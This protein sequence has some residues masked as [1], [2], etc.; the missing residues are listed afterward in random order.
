MSDG[1]P[2]TWHAGGHFSIDAGRK[3][4]PEISA[5]P[6]WRRTPSGVYVGS[7]YVT[8]VMFMDI[9]LPGLNLHWTPEAAA[10]RDRMLQSARLAKHALEHD[11]DAL[12]HL[13]HTARAPRKHQAQATQAMFHHGHRTLLADDMGLGKTSTALWAAFDSRVRR[14]FIV[15]PVGVKFNWAREIHQTLG[16]DWAVSIIAGTAKQRA[17]LLA[18]VP[19]LAKQNRHSA[20]IINYDLLRYLNEQQHTAIEA[21]AAEQATLCDESQYLKNEKAQRSQLVKQL[22]ARSRTMILMSGT[23]IMD[24]SNDLYAQIELLRPGTWRSRTDFESRYIVKRTIE[25]PGRAPGSVRKQEIIVGTKNKTELNT[26]VNTLQIRRMKSEVT[27]MPPKVFTKPDLE[28]DSHTRRLYNAM[29]DFAR[30]EME[31]LIG[32]EG[33]LNIFHP[34]ARSSVEASMRCEQL[35]QGFLGGIPDFLIE[36]I[37]P[38]L[39]HAEK[40]PGRPRELVFPKSAKMHW[41][42]ETIETLLKQGSAPIIGSRFNAPMF[43]LE[44]HLLSKGIRCTFMHGGL[45]DKQKDQATLDFQEKRIDV[46]ICQ[47]KIA[48]GWNATRSQDVIEYGRDWSPALNNQFQDRAHRMGQMGTVNVQTPVVRD[49][50]E[51]LVDKKLSAKDADAEQSLRNVSLSELLK[52]L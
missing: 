11:P 43:W 18:E 27:D 38:L 32:E 21:F 45:T 20:V 17:T 4:V 51:V 44:P 47:V 49:S 23:P 5:W 36:K 30:V 39:K 8:T 37:G 10:Q 22:S 34:R 28:L 13:E 41:L 46:L 48:C 2:I 35:A 1:I 9:K 25:L 12:Q 52:S 19:A 3:A 50:V 24:T 42:I 29:K 26:I 33:D 16:D 40:I 15:C 14:L 31:A 7:P 6:G